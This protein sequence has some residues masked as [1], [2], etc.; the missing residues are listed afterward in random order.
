MTE[1]RPD[2]LLEGLFFT[3]RSHSINEPEPTPLPEEEEE[4]K[5]SEVDICLN[6]HNF[7]TSSIAKLFNKVKRFITIVYKVQITNY[8]EAY[9]HLSI[10]F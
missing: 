5:P 8:L 4:T 9:Y 6:I 7:N 10:V 1:V 2:P 3:A